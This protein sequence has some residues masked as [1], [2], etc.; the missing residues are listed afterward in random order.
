MDQKYK[1]SKAKSPRELIWGTLGYHTLESCE[2]VNNS[3]RSNVTVFFKDQFSYW[4][5][6]MKDAEEK[7]PEIFEIIDKAENYVPKQ[8]VERKNYS[9]ITFHQSI[10]A[11][12]ISADSVLLFLETTTFAK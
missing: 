1:M 7:T 6:S 2:F 9:F 8:D 12:L 11:I 10:T 4:E 5:I 3:E